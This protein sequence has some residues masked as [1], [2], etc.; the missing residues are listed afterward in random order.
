MIADEDLVSAYPK[1]L[2][3]WQLAEHFVSVSGIW[4]YLG[5]LCLFT[6]TDGWLAAW[7]RCGL[8]IATTIAI[9]CSLDDVALYGTVALP[10]SPA[11]V[12]CRLEGP[13]TCRPPF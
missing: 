10:R 13:E 9:L 12:C 1:E 3:I 8:R 7:A 4:L 2:L 11:R 5:V 6:V